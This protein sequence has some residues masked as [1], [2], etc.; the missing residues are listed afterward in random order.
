MVKRDG[1]Y[2]VNSEISTYNIMFSYIGSV[3]HLSSCVHTDVTCVEVD[4]HINYV[5]YSGCL[6]YG[7]KSDCL[8]VVYSEC[9][10]K[11]NLETVSY[12]YCHDE[13]IPFYPTRV[14]FTK[15]W[16]NNPLRLRSLGLCDSSLTH[17]T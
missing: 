4:S 1:C 10:L 3:H 9:Q 7:V 6:V 16:E 15:N 8:G 14:A 13:K 11:W 17:F 12:R 5:K 2:Q